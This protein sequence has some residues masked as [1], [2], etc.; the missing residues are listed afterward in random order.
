MLE[1]WIVLDRAGRVPLAEQ[2]Y[3][4]VRGMVREG[5]VADG[6]PLPS[7]RMLADR[8]AVSRNTVTAAYDL[9]RAEGILEGRSGAVPVLV[10]P[11]AVGA[12]SP[13][14][15]LAEGVRLSRVGALLAE[16]R[17]AVAYGDRGGRL[18]PGQP[19][20]ALFPR[21]E[22]ARCLRRAARGLSG[23]VLLY[24]HME[25]VP[26][27]RRI[28][29]RVLGETRGLSVTEEQILVVP[30]VQ[31][32]LGMLAR[33]LVEAGDEV[34]IEEPGYLGARRAF[35]EARLVPMP[36]DEEGADVSGMEGRPR[37]MYVTPSHQYPL[38]VRM[39]LARRVALLERARA[40]GAVVIEDD[41]DSEFLWSGRP[42]PALGALAVRGEV[43]T[44]GTVA[45]SMLPGL[46]LAWMVA[47][48][49][50]AQV[51]RYAQVNLG[52]M[53]NVH[54]QEAF[55]SFIDS[56]QY[57]R[58]LE[59]ISGVY[60]ERGRVL[61]EAVRRWCGNLVSV[62]VP[63]GGLQVAVRFGEEVDDVA[64]VRALAGA[65][66]SVPALSRLCLAQ[67]GSGEAARGVVVSF[68]E[69]GQEEADR[70]GRVLAAALRG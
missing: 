10:L 8:L 2:I 47:P 67:L 38:G 19:D 14:L 37:V 26:R 13:V 21:D 64:V 4:Q 57:R 51:L 39:G 6:T 52:L 55:A 40:V 56:G 50:L 62:P 63:T 45:K 36:V 30:T 25:G 7:S 9:L 29:A 3:R 60:R 24:G 16:D 59:R 65:G 17:H 49:A 68:A 28:L 33:C 44:L 32:A 54:V 53:V 43:V 42:V 27:L 20:A 70:F 31:S 34:W 23:D 69:V 1:G 48:P 12:G 46:R 22:W 35:A 18:R 61:C 66:F 58:H 11:E 41:Y 15:D 5:R